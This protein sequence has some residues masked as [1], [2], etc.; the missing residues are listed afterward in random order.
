MTK[1]QI[2]MHSEIRLMLSSMIVFFVLIA[3]AI[4]QILLVIADKSG[5]SGGKSDFDVASVHDLM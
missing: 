3:N 4:S 1:I 5:E 2:E